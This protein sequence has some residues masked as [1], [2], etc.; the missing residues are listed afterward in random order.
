[1]RWMYAQDSR[2]QDKKQTIKWVRER[3]NSKG[4]YRMKRQVSQNLKDEMKDRVNTI[5]EKDFGE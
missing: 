2:K 1:M 4:N 3:W 5:K